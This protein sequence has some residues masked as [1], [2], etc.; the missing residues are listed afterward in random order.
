MAKIADLLAQLS[1]ARKL[2]L[3]LVLAAPIGVTLLLLHYIDG[4]QW[5]SLAIAAVQ[6][7][8]AANVGEYAIDAAHKY[9]DTAT[10]KTPE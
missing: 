4:Q 6:S 1:G 7:Y 5:T 10:G 8:C 2:L 9:I 3:C